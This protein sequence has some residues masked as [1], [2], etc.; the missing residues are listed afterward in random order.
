MATYVPY[1]FSLFKVAR[2]LPIVV[3]VAASP[4]RGGKGQSEKPI[5]TA[6][7]Q[8]GAR[9]SRL[10]SD[11]AIRPSIAESEAARNS[12]RQARNDEQREDRE[13]MA[14]EK[15]ANWT[16]WGAL[17]SAGATIVGIGAIGLGI[18]ANRTSARAL[19]ASQAADRAHISIVELKP[20]GFFGDYNTTMSFKFRN[21]GNG[22]GWMRGAAIWRRVIEGELPLPAIEPDQLREMGGT[23]AP[24]DET[25]YVESIVL[26]NADLD[27]V[28]RRDKSLYLIGVIRYDDVHG[29]ERNSR[30]AYRFHQGHWDGAD[31]FIPAGGS[32]Y[33]RNT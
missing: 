11:G 29:V 7:A 21:V 33:W 6:P 27:A 2:I 19:E 16:M 22:P 26:P 12:E 14:A 24:G 3:L 1:M 8:N 25:Y 32:A 5:A 13:L 4:P 30:F 31:A 23:I 20:H 17:G 18:A 28:L 10:M 15:S 9:P